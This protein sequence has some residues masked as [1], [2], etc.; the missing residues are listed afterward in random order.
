MNVQSRLLSYP[1]EVEWAGWRTDTFTLQRSGWR[2][3]VEHQ[4]YEERY[5]LL[6][7]HPEMRLY[8]LTDTITINTIIS[9]RDIHMKTDYRKPRFHVVKVA[10]SFQVVKIPSDFGFGNFKQIDATPVMTHTEIK[11]VEDYNIFAP[12]KVRAEE[13]LFNTANMSVIEHLEAIKRL[14]DPEQSE[15]RKRMIDGKEIPNRD[16]V[17]QLVEYR[18][19]G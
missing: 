11:S 1:I 18:K 3:A 19:H 16:V 4:G 13:I 8:A 15:I 2:L 12:F 14:Q 6:M 5:T 9:F 7:E 17:V 10:P